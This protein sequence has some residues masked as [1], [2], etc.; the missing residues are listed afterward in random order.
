M[1]KRVKLAA[2]LVV[3]VKN[4]PAN[5][6]DL[7]S[8]PG[9]GIETPHATGQLSL[10]ATTIELARLNERARMPQLERENLKAETIEK[11]KHRNRD[12]AL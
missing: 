1:N 5:A 3:V 10:R 8:S 2:S 9:R 7:G 4:L 12:R 11:P 6:G